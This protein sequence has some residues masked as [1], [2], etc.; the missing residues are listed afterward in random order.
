[1]EFLLSRLYYKMQFE[2]LIKFRH[3][4]F[5]YIMKWGHMAKIVSEM[6]KCQTKLLATSLSHT[7]NCDGPTSQWVVALAKIEKEPNGP[8]SLGQKC[9]Q[10]VSHAFDQHCTRAVNVRGHWSPLDFFFFKKKKITAI[11]GWIRYSHHIMHG[12]IR[13]NSIWWTIKL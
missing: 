7:K 2:L 12:W 6:L 4:I 9:T 11:Y 10:R 3:L 1:L 5:L 8:K 13:F